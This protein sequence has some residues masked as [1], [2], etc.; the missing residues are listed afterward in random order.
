MTQASTES[1]HP[2]SAGTKVLA[3]ED[4]ERHLVASIY[5]NFED[6]RP[7]TLSGFEVEVIDLANHGR[8]VVQSKTFEDIHGAYEFA[9]SEAHHVT[10][11]GS[12][13]RFFDDVKEGKSRVCP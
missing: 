2:V 11:D 9:Y 4:N 5:A 12:L 6:D 8:H 7:E 1:R 13:L 3:D 10:P